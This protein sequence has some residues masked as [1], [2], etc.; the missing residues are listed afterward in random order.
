MIFFMIIAHR[1]GRY[2]DSDGVSGDVPVLA[3]FQGICKL[4]PIMWLSV[5]HDDHHLGGA[6]PGSTLNTERFRARNKKEHVKRMSATLPQ[7]P[8][9]W[10]WIKKKTVT[11][12]K[13]VTLQL[14]TSAQTL[15]L[16]L[17]IYRIKEGWDT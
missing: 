15:L 12:K 2:T 11:K 14:N 17:D 10:F 1:M 13:I 5:G 8:A 7:D 3:L 4:L 6:L 16:I 9:E